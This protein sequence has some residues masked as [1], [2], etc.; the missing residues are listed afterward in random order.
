[1]RHVIARVKE[2]LLA[3]EI[4]KQTDVL[5]AIEWVA[6]T[7][8]EVTAEMTKNCFAKCGFTEETSETEDDIVDEEFN[9]LLNELADSDCEITAE[10]YNDFD[11]ETCNSVPAINLDTIDW[12]VSSVQKCVDI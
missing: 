8:K 1:M 2:D 10:E 5:H 11:V 12:R 9:A 6:K 7:W 4:A 3:S